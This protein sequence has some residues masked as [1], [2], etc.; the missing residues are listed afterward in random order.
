MECNFSEDVWNIVAAK[1][2]LPTHV[3]LN[4]SEGPLGWIR[5]VAASDT[6]R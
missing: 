5:Q 4:L 1:F 6:R 2:A 3:V